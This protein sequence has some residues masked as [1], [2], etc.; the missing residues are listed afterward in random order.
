[1]KHKRILCCIFLLVTVLMATAIPASAQE[2][3][4]SMLRIYSEAFWEC[5]GLVK[6][7]LPKNLTH[8]YTGAF[9]ECTGLVTLEIPASVEHLGDHIVHMNQL[10]NLIFLGD[11]P[12]MSDQTFFNCPVDIYYPAG[13][14]TWERAHQMYA[15][16]EDACWYEACSSHQFE[17][18]TVDPFCLAVGYTGKVCSVCGLVKDTGDY[19]PAIGHD[20]VIDPIYP[21]DCEEQIIAFYLCRRCNNYVEYIIEPIGHSYDENG[22]CINCS[23]EEPMYQNNELDQELLISIS[24]IATVSFAIMGLI[25]FLLTRNKK[26]KTE[27]DDQ[28][29][30]SP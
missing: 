22:V 23:P 7:E 3:P 8:I 29:G 28:A 24:V 17:T 25:L 9:N 18:V 4:D 10:E 27:T 20:L 2:V 15:G 30:E 21:P 6:L 26:T 19:V 1:M 13:N 14:D 5:T 16:N 11:M 12:E